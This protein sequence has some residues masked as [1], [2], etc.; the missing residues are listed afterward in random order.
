VGDRAFLIAL[1][2]VAKSFAVTL[3]TSLNRVGIV[4]H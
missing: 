1:D 2:K 3:L 4:H